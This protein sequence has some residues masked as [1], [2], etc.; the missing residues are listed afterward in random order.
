MRFG[1]SGSGLENESEG[2]GMETIGGDGSEM[3]PVM[4]KNGRHKSM[5]STCASLT[6]KDKEE[7]NNNECRLM[8]L[9]CVGFVIQ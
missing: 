5:T 9:S 7:S 8:L 3:G 2:W 6:C 4:K 1:G